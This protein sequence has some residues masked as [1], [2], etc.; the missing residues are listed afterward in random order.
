MSFNIALTREGASETGR[1][2]CQKKW[3]KTKIYV[4]FVIMTM[5]MRYT[6]QHEINISKLWVIS[7]NDAQKLMLF[8]KRRCFQITF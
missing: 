6:A 4:Y 3:F 2:S 7:P 5:T 8:S 1:V